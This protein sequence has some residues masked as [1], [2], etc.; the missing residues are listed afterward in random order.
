MTSLVYIS[1]ALTGA[2]VAILLFRQFARSKYRLLFWGGVCFTFLAAESFMIFIDL[3]IFP[4][5]DLRHYRLIC[6]L[7]GSLSLLCALIWETKST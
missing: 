1:C 4:G 5:T 6:T 7:F 3:I 2:V